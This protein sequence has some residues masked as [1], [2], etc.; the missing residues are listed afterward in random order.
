MAVS[1]CTFYDDYIEHAIE[2]IFI[3]GQIGQIALCYG[4]FPPP[5]VPHLD[6]SM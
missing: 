3:F 4:I 6:K 5:R 1:S 2:D